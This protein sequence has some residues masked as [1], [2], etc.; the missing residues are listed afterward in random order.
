MSVYTEFE[1]LEKAN[2]ALIG[3]IAEL[4]AKIKE[5]EE[6][7]KRKGR[8]TR[9]TL[10]VCIKRGKQLAAIRAILDGNSCGKQRRIDHI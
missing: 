1:R 3:E 10:D 9:Q 2:A 8:T 5:L 4:K 7:N 6:S